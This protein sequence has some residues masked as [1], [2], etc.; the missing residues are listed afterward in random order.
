MYVCFWPEPNRPQHVSVKLM[1]AWDRHN[2]AGKSAIFCWG[3]RQAPQPRQVIKNY[4]RPQLPTVL[5]VR[6]S[7]EGGTASKVQAI[8]DRGKTKEVDH[9]PSHRYVH[10]GVCSWAQDLIWD[11]SSA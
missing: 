10:G 1:A 9:G 3:R 6:P 7:N 11:A 2:P 8:G 5:G 4:L